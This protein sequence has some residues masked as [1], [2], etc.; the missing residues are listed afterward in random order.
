MMTADLLPGYLTGLSLATPDEAEARSR[1]L[2]QAPK[3]H[4]N[5]LDLMVM[6]VGG[7]LFGRLSFGASINF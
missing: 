6:V 3:I 5:K 1:S 7:L 2:S 4:Q